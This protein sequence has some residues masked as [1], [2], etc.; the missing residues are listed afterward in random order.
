MS[1]LAFVFLVATFLIGIFFGAKMS[2]PISRTHQRH[3]PY[4][5]PSIEQ[6][7]TP[8]KKRRANLEVAP[9]EFFVMICSALLLV[10]IILSL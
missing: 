2:S 4:R 10:L 7:P 9:T 6:F 1:L 8:N 5:H 3:S